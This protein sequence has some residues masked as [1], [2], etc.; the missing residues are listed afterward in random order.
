MRTDFIANLGKTPDLFVFL[1]YK[2]ESAG[3]VGLAWI[4]TI[5]FPNSAKGY[6]AGINECFSKDL[7]SA[8]VKHFLTFLFLFFF[9]LIHYVLSK[10]QKIIAH[11]IGHNLGMSHDFDPN[12]SNPSNPNDRFCTTD[13]S[14]C[15]GIGGIMD[16]FGVCLY[17]FFLI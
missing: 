11:E 4:G 1:T 5:C 16:Y 15:T 3:T 7:T 6:K 12:P 8:E 10:F 2:G 17:S 9:Y 13:E 14:L